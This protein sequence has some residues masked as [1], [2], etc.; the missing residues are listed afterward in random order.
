MTFVLSMKKIPM[1]LVHIFDRKWWVGL[2][3][4]IGF[5]KPVCFDRKFWYDS[6]WIMPG[7]VILQSGC[8]VKHALEYDPDFW[9]TID[10][11]NK[12]KKFIIGDDPF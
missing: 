3:L 9:Y 10:S 7:L 6:G 2:N 4:G 8:R 5:E 1:N 12:M 11:V